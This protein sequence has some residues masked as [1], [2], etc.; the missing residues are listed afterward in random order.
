MDAIMF[1]NDATA[2]YD[3]IIPSQAAMLSRCAGMP[4]AAAIAFMQVLFLMEYFVRTAYGVAST[5]YS[6][7][8]N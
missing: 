4:R 8:T 6:N 7:A 2:C 5:E 1:D 3:R